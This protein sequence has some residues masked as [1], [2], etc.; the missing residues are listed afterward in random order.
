VRALAASAT[1]V[2]PAH[3][4]SQYGLRV[5]NLRG[6]ANHRHGATS[7]DDGDASHNATRGEVMAPAV[8]AS[9]CCDDDLR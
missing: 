7:D 5:T 1:T 6:A 4:Q 9:T 2:L 3:R 8:A